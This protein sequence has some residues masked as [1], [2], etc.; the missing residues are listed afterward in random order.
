[1]S[2]FFLLLFNYSCLQIDVSFKN[3]RSNS[4]GQRTSQGS[5]IVGKNLKG[6]LSSITQLTLEL[7]QQDSWPCQSTYHWMVPESKSS[8]SGSRGRP[9]HILGCLIITMIFLTLTKVILQKLLCIYPSSILWAL[10][11]KLSSF[12][13]DGIQ[14]SR[15]PKSVVFR[16]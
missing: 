5:N 14:L 16:L 9:F 10:K 6:S 3:H 1:M 4:V 11:N 2:V 15:Y 8:L 12:S 13:T 7:L